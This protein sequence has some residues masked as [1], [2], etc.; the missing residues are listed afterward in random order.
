[1]LRGLD[2]AHDLIS[3]YIV[4]H[5]LS[6]ARHPAGILVNELYNLLKGLLCKTLHGF[7][8]W[9]KGRLF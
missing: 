2:E 6:P 4:R 3:L 9:W 1:M 8:K 7:A 5:L